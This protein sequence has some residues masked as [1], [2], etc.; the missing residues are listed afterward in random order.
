MTKAEARQII[1]ALGL[2]DPQARAEYRTVGRATTSEDIDIVQQATGDLLVKRT[3]PGRVG[4]QVFE[5][6]IR[7][8]GSKEVVQK[9]YDDAGN[10]VH[11]DPKGG[12]P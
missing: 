10:L 12:T 11:F 1:D 3:R 8:D 4:Y 5:D 9:A 2:P 7:P 6:T